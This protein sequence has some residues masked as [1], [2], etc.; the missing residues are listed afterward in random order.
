MKMEKNLNPAKTRG[1][2]NQPTLQHRKMKKQ[3]MVVAMGTNR[4]QKGKKVMRRTLIVKIMSMGIQS[5]SQLDEEETDSAEYQDVVDYETGRIPLEETD[6]IDIDGEGGVTRN[7]EYEG[8]GYDS[9]AEDI[10]R[11]LDAMV[12][13]DVEEG[14]EDELRSELQELAN[15]IRYGN[16]HKDIAVQ[17]NRM[18]HVSDHHIDG[19]NKVSKPLLTLSKRLQQQ[20]SQLLKDRREGGKL[21]GLLFGCLPPQLATISRILNGYTVTGS[22]ILPI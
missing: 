13:P 20:V 15:C 6:D 9:A 7:R 8:T 5:R 16:A 22:W 10:E 4:R 12:K 2:K 14:I 19:Y 11:L 18:T 1:A 3:E 21:T 17:V